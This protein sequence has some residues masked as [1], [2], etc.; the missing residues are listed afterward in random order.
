MVAVKKK[1]ILIFSDGSILAS[2]T[3]IKTSNKI[4]TLTKDHKTFLLNKKDGGVEHG[5][6]DLKGFKARYLK[7]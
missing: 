5:S 7:F 2:K 6:K 4:K 3:M 1:R